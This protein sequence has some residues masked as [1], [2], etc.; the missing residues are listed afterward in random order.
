VQLLLFPYEF[1]E[2]ALTGFEAQFERCHVLNSRVRHR[3]PLRRESSFLQQSHPGRCSPQ[4]YNLVVTTVTFATF[5]VNTI[6]TVTRT[7]I[8]FSM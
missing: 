3:L 4:I 2:L 6:F 5:E 8:R 1:R 7:S